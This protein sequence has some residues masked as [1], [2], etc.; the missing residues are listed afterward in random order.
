VDFRILGPLEVWHEGRPVDLTGRRQRALLAIML[1]NAGAVVS[2]DRLMD[3]LWGE[4]QPDTGGA[5]LRVRLSQLRKALGDEGSELIVSRPP[6]YLIRVVPGQLDLQRFERLVGEGERAM[7]QGDA[8]DAARSLAEADALWRGPALAD[9]AYAPFAQAP[10]AR[11]EEL[12]LTARELRIDAELAL[13]HHAHL[14]GELEGLVREHPL[15]ERLCGLLMLALYRDGRQADALAAYRS[16]RERLVEEAGIEPGRRLHALERQILT[17]DPS[18]EFAEALPAQPR[19]VLVLSFVESDDV[20]SLVALAE[21]L[22]AGAGH[23]L[24]VT[25]LVRDDAALPAAAARLRA[26][27][28]RFVQRGGAA[29]VAAFTSAEPGHDAVRLAAE[30]DVALMVLEAPR[31]L[32]RDGATGAGLAMVLERAV[33]DVAVVVGAQRAG[34]IGDDRAILVPFAGHEHDWAAVELGAWL[35]DA[36]GAPLQLLGARAD[37]STGRRDASRL[38]ASASL[39]LQRSLGIAAEPVLLQT[40]G[41]AGVLRAAERGAIIALGLPEAWARDGVGAARLE[42]A[43]AARTPVVLVRRGLR[44]GGLAPPAAA[45]R[46]TWSGAPG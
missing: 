26:V 37:P 43:R 38:L 5:A 1:V 42:V 9:F 36:R 22:A 35:A 30:Q 33:C 7:A 32:L 4:E 19:G 45:T 11:L 46:F 44:P 16:A 3:D 29:R 8:Q 13:G 24:L 20:E 40:A 10:I 17:Q 6:G 14:V 2:T 31:A 28:D 12:R 18:L 27:R 39:A 41:A 21:P 15:R 34:V 25:S 23:E